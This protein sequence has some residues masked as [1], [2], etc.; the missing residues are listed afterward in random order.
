MP[1][2]SS[3]TAV[4]QRAAEYPRVRD[5]LKDA[6]EREVQEQLRGAPAFFAELGAPARMPRFSQTEA[7]MARFSQT[8]GPKSRFPEGPFSPRRHLR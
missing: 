5:A 2:E 8:D 6:L 1:T 3:N 7:P 4:G